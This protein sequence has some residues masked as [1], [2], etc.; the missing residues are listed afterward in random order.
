MNT[1]ALEIIPGIAT[2]QNPMSPKTN[3]GLFHG[4]KVRAMLSTRLKKS[5]SPLVMP[6][7]S[8]YQVSFR[9]DQAK[10]AGKLTC[11]R[12]KRVF[13][14]T[15]EISARYGHGGSFRFW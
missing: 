6:S 2:I 1:T 14:L 15:V 11:I 7:F 8:Q 13:K 9:I 5:S 12:L 3:F 10:T 4:K